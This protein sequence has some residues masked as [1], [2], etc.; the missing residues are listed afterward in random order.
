MCSVV[1]VVAVQGDAGPYQI[2]VIVRSE[3]YP[4]GVREARPRIRKRSLDREKSIE[5]A[6]IGRCRRLV[7]TGKMAHQQRH[8]ETG[9]PDTVTDQ[10]VERL[11]AETESVD[12]GLDVERCGCPRIR[13]LDTPDPPI[14]A[15]EIE[16]ARDKAMFVQ[17]T[18]LCGDVRRQHEDLHIAE[19]S[20]EL[21]P[22]VTESGEEGPAP[23]PSTRCA[24][25]R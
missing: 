6:V 18:H 20:P 12:P 2:E 14:D 25:Y 4:G 16:Q 7:R 19:N 10:E 23:R 17:N 8:V 21:H 3:K 24:R 22:L 13:R 5:L 15:L 1:R 11:P 9:P